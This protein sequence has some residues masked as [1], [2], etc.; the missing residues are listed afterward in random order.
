VSGKPGP[1][2]VGTLRELGID[3]FHMD[4]WECTY[5][6]D[7]LDLLDEEIVDSNDPWGVHEIHTL[8]E[9]PKLYAAR[10]PTDVDEDGDVHD[11][12]LLLFASREEAEA[13]IARAKTA[14]EG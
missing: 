7:Q 5:N 6:Y 14:K 1:N 9:G 8:I 10:V 13:A 12:E 2:G 4:E 11:E 3:H